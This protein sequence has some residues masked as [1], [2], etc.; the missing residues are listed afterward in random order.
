MTIKFKDRKDAAA[1]LAERLLKYRDQRPAVL[2]LPRGGVAIGAVVAAKLAAPLDVIFVRKIGA[3]WQPELAVAAVVDGIRPH[4]AYNREIMAGLGIS[5]ADVAR[6]AQRELAEIERRRRVYLRDRPRLDIKDKTAIV[7]DDGIATGATVLAALDAARNSG[8]ATLVLAV[9]VAPADIIERLRPLVDE[10][11]CLA[12]PE[13][14]M[15]ISTWYARFPQLT[16]E[17]VVTLLDE[18][19]AR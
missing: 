13:H 11:I 12:A 17:T 10:F 15:A 7:V 2:A 14:L 19:A 9:P 5:E 8:P 4:T 6:E 3:P 16:D 1:Q 18:A